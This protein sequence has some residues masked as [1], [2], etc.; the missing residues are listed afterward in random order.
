MAMNIKDLLKP[1]IDAAKSV[2]EKKWPEVKTY[3]ETEFKKIGENIL[4]IEA[5]KLQ[6]KITE[7]QAKLLFDIQKNASS[8]IMLTIE[9]IGKINAERIINSALGA[10]KD[11][12]NKALGFVL[13]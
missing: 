10:V 6:G 7:E 9:G 3:A 12:V 13:I 11:I 5:L 4:M 2:I 1:M 8:S